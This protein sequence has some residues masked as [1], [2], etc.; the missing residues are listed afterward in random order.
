LQE[1][2]GE[3]H[4]LS[5]YKFF[6]F[7]GEIASCQVINRTGPRAGYGSFYDENWN[8][9]EA[10]H[11]GYPII[12]AQPKPACLDEM[13]GQVKKLSRAY[14][15]FVRIDFYATTKGAVFGEFTPTPGLGYGYSV[16]GQKLL[17][18]YWDKY[19]GGLV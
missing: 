7:N 15:I 13:I 6:C 4:I 2:P 14:Q 16:Y 12:K 18:S 1:E 17:L 3:Y 9:M 8:S 19:C 10:V 5:D 11:P